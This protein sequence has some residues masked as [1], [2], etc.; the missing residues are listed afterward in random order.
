MNKESGEGVPVSPADF[1]Q[2]PPS[3][4][5]TAKVPLSRFYDAKVRITAELGRLQMPLGELM[6]LGPGAVLE[7]DRTVN[8]A[9]DIVAQGVRIAGGEV[10]VVHDRY[11]IR[12]TEID[13]SHAEV[14]SGPGARREAQNVEATT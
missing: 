13:E 11:G 6:E 7:L 5:I 14:A 1:P 10:V 4:P 9:L 2:A 12:I 3:G 8:D